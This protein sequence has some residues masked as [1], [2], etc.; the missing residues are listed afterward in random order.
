MDWCADQG[1]AVRF[2]PPNVQKFNGVVESAI[3]RANKAGKAAIRYARRQLGPGWVSCVPGIDV[4]GDRLYGETARWAVDAFNQS[5]T[6]ANPGN[7]SLYEVFTGRKGP[8]RMLS[9]F[10]Q[11]LMWIRRTHKLG[12][13]ATEVFHLN[14]GDHHPESCPKVINGSTGRVV[15][16]GGVVQGLGRICRVRHEGPTFSRRPQD[17]PG[18]VR[19]VDATTKIANATDT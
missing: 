2:S 6:T 1:I 19:N 14:S 7:L 9:F 15:P 17:I 8:F 13:K 12:D 4:D 5:A 3:L 11:G 18:H 16:G 10:K